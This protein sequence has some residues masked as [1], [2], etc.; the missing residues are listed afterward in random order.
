M[1]RTVI[2]AVLVAGSIGLAGCGSSTAPATSGGSAASSS[3]GPVAVKSG[4]TVDLAPIMK[5]SS[6][7]VL[8]KKTAHLSM[9][10]GSGAVQADVDYAGASTAMKMSM[11]AAGQQIE[12]IFVDK[13][14]YFGGTMAAQLGA[15]KKW[16]K[17]DP[18]GTDAF[19]KQMAPLLGQMSTA[20]QDP[21]KA[22]GALS[23]V[24]ATVGSVDGRDTTYAVSLDKAQVEQM[25]RA[26]GVN[27]LAGAPEPVGLSYKI[28]LDADSLPVTVVTTTGG[29]DSTISFTKW[30]QPV[31]ISAP[32]ASEV[33]SLKLPG[34]TPTTTS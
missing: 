9:N 8:A 24:K 22:L 26:S 11:D 31:D 10:L 33:G 19:S 15:G 23:G 2:T 3:V 20:A 27:G 5:N 29:V 14:L 32:P 1:K 25:L 13:A 21:T 16:L 34:M 28:T 18:K 4:D 6:A 12:M 30:G 17:I 7:A